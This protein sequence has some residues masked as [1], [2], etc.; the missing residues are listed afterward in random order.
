MPPERLAPAESEKKEAYE[1][2]LSLESR[3]DSIDVVEGKVEKKLVEFGWPEDTVYKFSV[4]VHEALAN[5]IIHG[6]L[7]L[8]MGD[9]EDGFPAAVAAA[10]ELEENKSKRVKVYIRLSKDDA[11]VQIKDEGTFVPDVMMDPTSQEGLLKGS[12][13][14]F[15]MIN[16]GIDNLQFFPGEIIL[17]KQNKGDEDGI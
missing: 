5:A 11:T 10:E 17:H 4:A 13:R 1:E 12:G 15:L 8:K 7:G 16:M 3:R 14:G 6:N 9:N 2:E